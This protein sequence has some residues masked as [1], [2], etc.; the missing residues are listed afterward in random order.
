MVCCG[1]LSLCGP[2]DLKPTADA[3][4]CRGWASTAL[5]G[6]I[7]GSAMGV[8]GNQGA[9]CQDEEKSWLGVPAMHYV[10]SPTDSQ[11][12]PLYLTK[13]PW[14]N[15]SGLGLL[16]S[17]CASKLLVYLLLFSPWYLPPLVNIIVTVKSLAKR[18][19]FFSSR[20]SVSCIFG[21]MIFSVIPCIAAAIC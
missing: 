1:L 2:G 13:E 10:D 20:K 12:K 7:L 17:F 14:L 11:E 18:R 16:N 6:S 15:K 3:V 5:Q 21:H 9:A 4:G 8:P 19:G